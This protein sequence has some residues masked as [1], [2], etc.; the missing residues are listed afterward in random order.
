MDDDEEDMWIPDFDELIA[1][2]QAIGAA[3][4]NELEYDDYT[5]M[6]DA[7]ENDTCWRGDVDNEDAQSDEG[8]A[9]GNENDGR[10]AAGGD[11]GAGTMGAGEWGEVM[12]ECSGDE[13]RRDDGGSGTS[14]DGG[15]A[16]AAVGVG[17]ARERAGPGKWRRVVTLAR[18][19]PSARAHMLSHLKD[20][21]ID[22]T[23]D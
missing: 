14:G 10:G 2:D 7:G 9:K 11:D 22:V 19:E 8:G 17:R 21:T 20:A 12:R 4:H 16:M 15:G 1:D 23:G 5:M 6:Q 18:W 13:E 3:E